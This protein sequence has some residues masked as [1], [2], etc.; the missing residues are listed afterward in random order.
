MALR[1]FLW[2][3]SADPLDHWPSVASSIVP[4]DSTKNEPQRHKVTKISFHVSYESSY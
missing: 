4:N 2:A 1:S 3:A